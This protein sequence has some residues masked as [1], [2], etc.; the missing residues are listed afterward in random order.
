MHA[1]KRFTV[2]T[3][4]QVYF[5]DPRSPWQR[6]SNEN[7]NG[8]LRQ[9]FP[10]GSDRSLRGSNPDLRVSISV[11]RRRSRPATAALVRGDAV[12][13]G[14]VAG[15]TDVEAFPWDTRLSW[16]PYRFFGH[17]PAPAALSAAMR[18][19]SLLYRFTAPRC[20]CGARS[21]HL[22]IIDR[23]SSS[24]RSRGPVTTFLAPSMPPG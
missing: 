4:V 15:A 18:R 24:A 12:P 22:L 23:A 6:G 21:Y 19:A 11:S 5:C 13:D 7:T 1:H 8:L 14:G 10:R 2:A 17:P 3:N 9:Y 16:R 20:A